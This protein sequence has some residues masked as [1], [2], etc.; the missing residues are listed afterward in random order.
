MVIRVSSGLGW[1]VLFSC[2]SSSR[3]A[4]RCSLAKVPVVVK[5]MTLLLCLRKLPEVTPRR[6]A[7]SQIILA[8]DHLRPMN[9]S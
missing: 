5:V 3:R 9:G 8:A 4:L 7:A 6:G 1:V 2:S